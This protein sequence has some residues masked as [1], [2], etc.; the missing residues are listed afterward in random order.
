MLDI[1]INKYC[2][3]P[4][5]NLASYQAGTVVHGALRIPTA[6]TSAVYPYHN[7]LFLVACLRLRPY[8]KRKAVLVKCVLNQTG[9]RS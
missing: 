8:V 9:Q 2:E 5:P 7:R 6:K 4:V 3:R 1:Y